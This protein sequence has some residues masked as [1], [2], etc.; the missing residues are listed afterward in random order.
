M[1]IRKTFVQWARE[2][3][4]PWLAGPIG[5]LYTQTLGLIHDVYVESF[6]QGSRASSMRSP[7]FHVSGL[8]P[9][10]TER[11]MPRYDSET[12]DGYKL[13]LLNAFDAWDDAGNYTSVVEQLAVY[14]VTAEIWEQG[15]KGPAPDKDSAVI[16]NWDDDTSEWSRFFVVITAHPWTERV[17]DDGWTYDDGGTWGSDATVNEVDAVRGICTHWKDAHAVFPHIIVVM[18]SVAWA[19]V[20]PVTTGDRYDVFE[21]RSDSAIYWDGYGVRDY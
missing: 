10:G 6:S 21:N 19:L 17:W 20:E 7:T 3:A 11:Q 15:Q 1:T 14:G 9:I 8:T 12:D 13:R 2:L 5:E 4:P 18:D 16:W